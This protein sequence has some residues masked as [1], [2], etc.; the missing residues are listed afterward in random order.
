MPTESQID[1]GL[2]TVAAVVKALAIAVLSLA[3]GATLCL[4]LLLGGTALAAG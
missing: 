4:A 3:L 2:A 1:P